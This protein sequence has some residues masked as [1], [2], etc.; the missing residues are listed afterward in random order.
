M[1]WKS[2]SDLSSLVDGFHPE[3]LEHEKEGEG[4]YRVERAFGSFS[5]RK[6]IHESLFAH[7]LERSSKSFPGP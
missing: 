3:L 6:V 4:F 5:R 7:A 1:K 2:G